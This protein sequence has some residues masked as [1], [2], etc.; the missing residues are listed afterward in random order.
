MELTPSVTP[1]AAGL[2]ALAHPVRLKMLGMLRIDGPATATSL[3]ARLGL[4]SGATSYH[5]RQ[6]AD[7]GFI[8]DDQERGNG[9]ER[10]W[11][12][13]HASTRTSS[14]SLVVPADED[15]EAQEGYLRAVATFYTEQ[16]QDAVAERAFLPDAWRSATTFSD[17]AIRLTPAR[18]R[19]LLEA[20]EAVIE[21]VPED[22][23]AE[24]PFVIQVQAFPQPG[25]VS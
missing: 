21:D 9:R 10:W 7:H 18:A 25:A 17:W 2:K 11:K 4:N 14:D 20:V 15:H 16:L 13:A 24:V 12:A 19:A 22:D 8:V 3:A 6:L 5:L 23:D 1:D